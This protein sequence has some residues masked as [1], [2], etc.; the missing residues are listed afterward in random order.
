MDVSSPLRQ[1]TNDMALTE[2][3]DR[4]PRASGQLIGGKFTPDTLFSIF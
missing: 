2:D 1:V 4:T 3:G